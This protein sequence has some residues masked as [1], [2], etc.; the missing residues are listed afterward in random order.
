MSQPREDRPRVGVIGLGNMGT[1][2]LDCLLDAG[3]P[4]LCHDLRP[5]PV[6]TM[7]ARGAGAASHPRDLAERSDVVITFLPGPRQVASAALDPEYGVLAGLS[8]RAILLD[9]S[10][11]GPDTAQL[12]GRDFDAAGRRYVDCP[13]SRRAPEMTVLVGGQPGVLGRAEAVVRAASRT[14]VY[15]GSRGAGYAIKLLN[16]HVK[17]A[18][19]L[20]SAEAL[21]VARQLGLD[22]E[23]VAS[24]IG[25]CSGG[26]SG[27]SA[28]ALYFRAD[29]AGMRSRAP[30]RT[31]EKDTLLAEAMAQDAGVRSRTLDVLTDFFL[32]VADTDY[33]ERP[34]PE[35]S[36][37]LERLRTKPRRD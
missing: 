37:L 9:M 23:L 31:I 26:E 11:C 3:Y 35:S 24:A 27:L 7:V 22:P 25:Q 18:W 8:E 28:A 14:L 17:Y 32:T 2:L 5:E 34:Y 29:A 16:Q 4:T 13:V 33:R 36:E 21:V 15:C 30:A 12:L 1:A 6:A 20:A 10:T 19:Y